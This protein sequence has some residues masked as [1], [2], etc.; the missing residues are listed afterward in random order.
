MFEKTIKSTWDTSGITGSP[1][2]TSDN[3]QGEVTALTNSNPLIW[4]RNDSN[5]KPYVNDQIVGTVDSAYTRNLI[6]SA[7]ITS[8]KFIQNTTITEVSDSDQRV[9][10]SSPIEGDVAIQF[11]GGTGTSTGISHDFSGAQLWSK[12]VYL[13]SGTN[14]LTYTS[15]NDVGR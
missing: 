13:A 5:W 1:V 6:D 14:S 2:N 8:L 12:T 15:A 7:Y 10:I 9:A 11:R 3:Y 4:H